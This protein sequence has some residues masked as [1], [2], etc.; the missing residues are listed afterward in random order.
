MIRRSLQDKLITVSVLLSQYCYFELLYDMH[1]TVLKN[2][3]IDYLFAATK[4][5]AA[6][7]KVCLFFLIGV[8]TSG[9]LQN[10]HSEC[11]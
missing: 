1:I 8:N 9:K 4:I 7:T 5:N 2:L 3:F 10:V 6:Q 11:I